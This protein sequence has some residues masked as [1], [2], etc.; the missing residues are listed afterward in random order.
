M[1]VKT[2]A[3]QSCENMDPLIDIKSLL[4]EIM[5]KLLLWG[6]AEEDFAFSFLSFI[7]VLFFW[8][9][10][11]SVENAFLAPPLGFHSL[12]MLSVDAACAYAFS[13]C[14]SKE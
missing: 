9:N 3:Y 13:L 10:H 8:L 2:I 1:H 11:L 4:L 14:Y 7:R 12:S 5:G 6:P